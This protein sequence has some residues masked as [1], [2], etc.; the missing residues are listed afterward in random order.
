[1]KIYEEQVF[2][3]NYL[4]NP[5]EGFTHSIPLMGMKEGYIAD[6]SCP[7]N[8]LLIR[9]MNN[10]KAKGK[11]FEVSYLEPF[12]TIR[13]SRGTNICRRS[14][15]PNIIDPH[16]QPHFGLM[17][18]RPAILILLKEFDRA[19]QT[20][21]RLTKYLPKYF[22]EDYNSEE[23]HIEL[24]KNLEMQVGPNDEYQEEASYE[25]PELSTRELQ[26]RF[27]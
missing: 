27:F 20:M 25:V 8:S 12:I 22:A 9:A 10:H 26:T 23:E 18:N 3:T 14:S 1:M 13:T 15:T 24:M 2:S 19:K 11:K 7:A 6:L 21:I 5:E 4:Q 17:L 16:G